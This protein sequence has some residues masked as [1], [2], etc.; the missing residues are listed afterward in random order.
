MFKR[1]FVE[2]AASVA[3][4]MAVYAVVT[5]AH[6]VYKGAKAAFKKKDEDPMRDIS[7]EFKELL[8]ALEP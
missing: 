3:A 6:S 8:A 4:L 2:T 1:A 7:E 5:V